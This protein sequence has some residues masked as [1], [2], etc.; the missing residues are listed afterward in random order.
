M[1]ANVSPIFSPIMFINDHQC[2][3]NVLAGKCQTWRKLEREQKIAP[4]FLVRQCFALTPIFPDQKNC[5]L[6]RGRLL[7]GLNLLKALSQILL[8]WM[9]IKE[10]SPDGATIIS[11]LRERTRRNF[12]SFRGSRSRIQL[13]AKVVKC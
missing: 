5:S 7:H 8:V 6:L 10:Y 11:Y 12:R 1:F 4:S 2:C 13:R 3:S 9:T